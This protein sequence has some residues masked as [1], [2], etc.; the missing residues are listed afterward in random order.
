MNTEQ[1]SDPVNLLEI[2]TRLTRTMDK[3]T[4]MRLTGRC[5]VACAR[6]HRPGEPFALVPASFSP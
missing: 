5:L 6:T 2:N 4:G 3:S 1:P